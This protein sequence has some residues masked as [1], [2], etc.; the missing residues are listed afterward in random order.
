[1][2]R[3]SL[4][5]QIQA[6]ISR[7]RKRNVFV[8]EDFAYLSEYD[9]VG[10]ALLALTREGTLLRIGYGL[11]AKARPNRITGKPMLA[12]KGGFEQVAKEALDVLGVKWQPSSSE[13]S[14]NA[15]NTQIPINTEVIITGRFNRQIRTDKYKLQVTH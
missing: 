10:R 11:Y 14:Y 3:N 5:D 1:M 9:Q 2:A 12:A 15:G 8:R 4:K 6:K 7:S 13:E